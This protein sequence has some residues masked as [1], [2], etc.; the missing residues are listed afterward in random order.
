MSAAINVVIRQPDI[1]ETRRGFNTFG[2]KFADKIHKLFNY[3]N[4]II[5]HHGSKLSYDT[6]GFGAWQDYAGTFAAITGEQIRTTRANQNLYLTTNNGLYKIDSITNNP[7][8]AGGVQALDISAATTGSSGFLDNPSQCAYRIT[9]VYTDANGTLIEG[10]PSPSVNVLNNSGTT[11]NVNVTF[12]VPSTVTTAYSYRIYRTPQTDSLTVTPGDNF[13]LAAEVKVTAAQIA[14]KQVTAL[15]A[16]PDVL[17]GTNLYTNANDQG[18]LQ[19][20]DPPPLAKDV[21]TFLGMTMY[22]NCSTLQQLFVN[23]ISVGSPN[24]IQVGDT[25]TFVGASTHVY[26]GDSS[27]NFAAQKFKVDTSGTIA[28]NI[29]NTARNL[30]AAINQDPTNTEIYAYYISGFNQLPGQIALKARNLSQAA[31]SATSSRGSVFNPALP[32]SGTSYLSTNT[33]VTN[34]VYVSKINQPE[35]VP[36][37]NLIFVGTGTIFR[38][39]ALRNSVIVEASD[40]CFR[41]TGTSPDTLQV[42]P[43]DNTVIQHGN[44]TGV[45]LNNS[46]YSFTTQGILS[47][48]ESSPQIMSRSVEG[49]LLRLSSQSVFPNFLSLAFGVSYESERQYIL[50]MAIGEADTVSTIQY[51]YNWITNSFVTWNLSVTCGM[52]NPLDNKLYFGASDGYV[53]QERKDFTFNDYTDRQYGV[54]IIGANGFQVTLDST[55]TIHAGY[56]LVQG[57]SAD[58]I[59]RETLIDSVDGLTLTVRDSLDWQGGAA[60]AYTPIGATITYLPLHGGYPNYLKR[61]QPVAGFAFSQANF[62]QAVVQY[63]T[64]LSPTL[65]GVSMIS[66]IE[67]VGLNPQQLGQWGTFGFGTLNWPTALGQSLPLQIIPTVIP[68]NAMLAH[69]LNVSIGVNQAFR[70]LALNG[71]IFFY[72]IVAQRYR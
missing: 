63:T 3:Q 46:V 49:D 52:V 25:V 47:V 69:W 9:W 60:T 27:N 59:T 39:Y 40:G 16:T 57:I 58:G 17:L 41:I 10:T 45:V 72:D 1:V 38:G 12:T 11:V 23:L 43:F 20:N 29:D 51:V 37:E 33:T 2:S 50:G 18:E 67:S 42:A 26:T 35:A 62:D 6:T 31:F 36:A 48:G 24:G 15:D 4:S 22:L 44:E 54:N 61:F 71:G 5:V 68:R 34:G 21:I 8:Q 66:P 56:S 70:N 32:S 7:Y 13:Q 19:A 28:Q 64:D 30:T 65:E 55:S 14:A 53:I